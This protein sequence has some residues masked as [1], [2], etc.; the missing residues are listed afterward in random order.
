MIASNTVCQ[1]LALLHCLCVCACSCDTIVLCV[2]VHPIVGDCILVRYTL[3]EIC[4]ELHDNV[5]NPV[6]G[7]IVVLYPLMLLP[8]GEGLSC[9]HD[10]TCCYLHVLYGLWVFFTVE[11]TYNLFFCLYL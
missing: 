5:I 8:R 9:L 3:T 4:I 7:Y 2:A 6:V 1:P 11:L 10:I